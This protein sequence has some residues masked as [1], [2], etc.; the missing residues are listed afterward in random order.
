MAFLP[1]GRPLASKDIIRVCI[2]AQ[3]ISKSLKPKKYI[4]KRFYKGWKSLQ[5]IINKIHKN[6]WDIYPNGNILNDSPDNTEKACPMLS[7]YF[8]PTITCRRWLWPI[9]F[10]GY[11]LEP[12]SAWFVSKYSCMFKLCE[13]NNQGICIQCIYV[14]EGVAHPKLNVWQAINLPPE[15][16]LLGW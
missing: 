11:G 9:S 8:P 13:Q 2:W 14:V 4:A 12:Y 1:A 10:P 15:E 7:N 5:K 3:K 16:P 6:D